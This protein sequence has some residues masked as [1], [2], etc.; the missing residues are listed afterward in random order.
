MFTK[1]E[2]SKSIAGKKNEL[3]IKKLSIEKVQV[4]VQTGPCLETLLSFSGFCILI[5][6]VN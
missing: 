6:K 3:V 5:C 2:N 4:L 1:D